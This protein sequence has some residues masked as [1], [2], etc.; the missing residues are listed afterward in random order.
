MAGASAPYASRRKAARPATTTSAVVSMKRFF[1]ASPLKFQPVVTS[2]FSPHRLHPGAARGSRAP[3]RRLPRARG[4]PVVAVADGVVVSAGFSGG[5][6]RIV[7]LRH[8]NGIRD[9]V[10]AFVVDQRSRWRAGAAGRA[11]RAR[12]LERPRDRAAS[13]LSSEEERRVHQPDHRAPRDAAGRS[14]SCRRDGSVRVERAIARSRLSRRQP[15]PASRI[16]TL[17][18]NN[19][20][21]Q[22]CLT[23]THR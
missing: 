21:L 8:A 4:A 19:G 17:P 20:A 6:G 7:H 10:S 15:W 5:G 12:R 2:G 1:L 13:R 22:R 23:P 3:R 11:H 18:C 16:Q 14:G 9:R